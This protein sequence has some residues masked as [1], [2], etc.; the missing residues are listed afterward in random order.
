MLTISILWSSLFEKNVCVY[1]EAICV[2]R[3]FCAPDWVKFCLLLKIGTKKAFGKPP[4]YIRS[5]LFQA[6]DHTTFMSYTGPV[7]Q[8]SGHQKSIMPVFI[9]GEKPLVPFKIEE[10]SHDLVYILLL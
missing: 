3:Y 5:Y 4:P 1:K 6:R 10:K 9:A 7:Y 2:G 8:L